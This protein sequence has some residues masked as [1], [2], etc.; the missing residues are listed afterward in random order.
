MKR[1]IQFLLAASVVF[2]A[3]SANAAFRIDDP[4]GIIPQADKFLGDLKFETSFKVG[5]GMDGKSQ[6]C[7]ISSGK[8]TCYPSVGIS[9]KVSQVL[10]DKAVM[11]TKSDGDD[12]G[13][14]WTVNRIDFEK[15]KGD[16]I[17]LYLVIGLGGDK[18]GDKD[19]ATIEKGETSTFVM[20]SGAKVPAFTATITQNI[21]QASSA[22]YTQKKVALT[23][24]QGLPAISQ[25]LAVQPDPGILKTPIFKVVK[26]ARAK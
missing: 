12:D 14:D 20:E 17:T 8:E 15:V 2:T 16:F 4:S 24:G 6:F 10:S 3:V 25:L 7:K 26:F 5:D 19:F 13:S 1:S 18:P 11:L 9:S 21:W 22:K 23:V